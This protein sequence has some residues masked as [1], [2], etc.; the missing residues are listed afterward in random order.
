M[1]LLHY[2]SSLNLWLIIIIHLFLIPPTCL[3][4]ILVKTNFPQTLPQYS[5][6][7]TKLEKVYNST[8]QY[9]VITKLKWSLNPTYE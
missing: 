5:W 6:W 9:I 7:L 8:D 2:L 4:K 3:T 1:S